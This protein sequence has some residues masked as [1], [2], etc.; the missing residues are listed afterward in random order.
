MLVMGS[1]TLTRP[2]FGASTTDTTFVLDHDTV[3]VDDIDLRRHTPLVYFS[4]RSL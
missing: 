2:E 3:V 1:T 4:F